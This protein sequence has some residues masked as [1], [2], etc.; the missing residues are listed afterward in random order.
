M[1]ANDIAKKANEIALRQVSAQVLILDVSHA[2]EFIV[3]LDPE[4]STITMICP[5]NIHLKN[6]GGESTA[7]TEFKAVI[8][9]GDSEVELSTD[10]DNTASNNE[11]VL[12]DF[13][14][15]YVSLGD[16]IPITI[17]SEEDILIPSS[18]GFASPA[19]KNYQFY[20]SADDPKAIP[21]GIRYFITFSNG[22]T[23][24]SEKAVCYDIAPPE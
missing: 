1:E 17:G 20:A 6:L 12:S 5:L 4:P 11:A 14:N 2:D 9:Y 22:K 21:L 15:F 10:G 3:D 18:V 19:D 24:S 13:K 23:S 7:I 16:S 8:S